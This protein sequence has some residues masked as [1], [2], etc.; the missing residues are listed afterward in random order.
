[1]NKDSILL[2]TKDA[3]PTDYL[4]C[5]GNTYW[6]GKTPNMD[7]MVKKGTLFTNFYTAA[8]SSA[9]A[10]MAMFTGKYSY[11]QNIKKYVPLVNSYS[12]ETLFD[13]ARAKGFECHI[14]WDE[15][16]MST[17]YKHS[18]CYGEGTIF[19]PLHGL[20][21][22]VGFHYKHEGFLHPDK[23]KE[24]Q[25]LKMI[26]DEISKIVCSNQKVFVWF[27]LPHVINGRV[28][29]G[30]DI[31]V[32]D[33]VLG[34]M[35]TFFD[36]SNIFISADHGNMN[37]HKGILGYGFH[38][39]EHA[40]KIPLITPRKAG[41]VCCNDLISNIDLDKIIFDGDKVPKREVIISDS[42]YYAQPN[43]KTVFLYENYRYIYNKASKTEELYDIV[44][45]P[46]QSFNLIEDKCYD[47]DRKVVN[48]SRELYFYPYWDKLPAIREKLRA[49]KDKIWKE[50]S[51]SQKAINGLS[52][53][54]KKNEL[55]RAIGKKTM[56]LLFKH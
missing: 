6:K 44:W 14:I 23:E 56:R 34:I 36:D 51:F 27:H 17:S 9:M 19:H 12:G 15:I 54:M 18:L 48:I 2:F 29:Y 55:M 3:L 32:H 25:T 10:Y 24:E 50:E 31:D 45:D 33:K 13:K 20:R 52:A 35:R 43:R 22:G 40:I 5:Y 38:V 47:E 46:N 39:Y 21:Q 41:M 53:Q 49:E 37:G 28:G 4:P 8:P 7:E 26:T 11:E 42:A 1:M 16:W 30:T